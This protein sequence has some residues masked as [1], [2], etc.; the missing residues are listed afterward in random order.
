MLDVQISFVGN[1][2]I[3]SHQGDTF[4]ESDIESISSAGD[5]TK[6]ED[7]TKTGFKGIGFKS[8]FSHSKYVIIKSKNFC[9]R[10]D[11]NHW[12]NYWDD[13][14]WG[15]K[16]NWQNQRL[17][18]RK[19]PDFKMPWQIIPIWTDF[20][21]ELESIDV[22]EKFNVS[23]IIKYDEIHNLQTTFTQLLSNTQIL[24]FLR[25]QEI[26]ITL[27]YKQNSTITKSKNGE[28]T[29][30]KTRNKNGT[31]ISEWIIK[32][33]EFPLPDDVKQKIKQDEK[34]PEKLRDSSYTEIA[35]AIKLEEGKL[36]A[37]H[38]DHRL[39]FTYLP[40]S[41]NYNFP[42][43]VNAPFLA[44]AGRE[45]LHQDLF[46]NKFIFEQ[47]PFKLLA[48]ASELA[49]K[50]SK[51][52]KQFLKIIPHKS[53]GITVL[54]KEFYRSYKSA[55]DTIA[56]IPNQNG[57]LLKVS[58]AIFDKP[59]ISNVIGS[60]ILISYINKKDKICFTLESLVSQL[61]DVNILKEIGVRIFDVDELQHFLI[62]DTFTNKHELKNNFALISFLYEEVQKL[63]ISHKNIWKDKLHNIPFIFD[64]YEKLKSPQNIY[65]DSVEFSE[66]LSLNVSIIHNHLTTQIDKNSDIRNWLGDLGVKEP[67]VL[68]FIEKTIIAECETYI[69]TNNALKIGRFL[70]DA[71]KK[72]QLKEEHYEGL[73]NSKF[74]TQNQNLIAAKS[75][76]LSDF[77]EPELCL[78][79]VYSYDFYVFNQYVE[80]VNIKG[81]WK[82]FLLKIGVNQNITLQNITIN[83][84]DDLDKIEMDYF[85]KVE[86][87][88]KKE[89]KYPWLINESNPIEITK[90]SYSE[91]A[92]ENCDFAKQFWQQVFKKI[93]LN[94]INKT[95]L[96]L[97]DI[98]EVAKA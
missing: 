15:P 74:L 42:F 49:S 95:A 67:S 18:N 26:R 61:E 88:A 33:Y 44:D 59:S 35:F 91:I 98:M 27:N 57:K 21:K 78:E 46:W 94:S 54:E 28:V 52:N 25:S 93:S 76:Y 90:I 83:R 32:K 43:L 16:T 65:F 73:K 70:F 30:I 89:H 31:I 17:A 10:Y 45:H 8:V 72:G 56:F 2:A 20:P 55:L 96:M 24:L 23:I 77:Y 1:Y 3:I 66:N 48:F 37:V 6:R 87:E 53:Q 86:E 11:E 79:S 63:E 7:S 71:H 34:L 9:F 75:A 92:R 41:I 14:N 5:G 38:K 60:D 40:T 85:L 13:S 68:S 39:I 19:D 81:E 22:W 36:K 84:S 12:K 51:Y 4:K 80:D 97:G 64:Q 69:T 47:I 62:S 29:T 82:N 50:S 58:E